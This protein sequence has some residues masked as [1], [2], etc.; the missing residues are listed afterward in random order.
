MSWGPLSPQLQQEA[1][2][3]PTAPQTPSSFSFRPPT[4]L[5]GRHWQIGT[6]LGARM[7]RQGWVAPALQLR[8][9]QTALAEHLLRA[10]NTRHACR[11]RRFQPQGTVA[12]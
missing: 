3:V 10:L 4:L 8:V 1:W 9:N 5:G 11:G 6:S 7:T 12:Q 2:V